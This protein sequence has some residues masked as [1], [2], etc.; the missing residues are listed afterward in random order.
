MEPSLFDVW[1][2]KRMVTDKEDGTK[3]WVSSCAE[4]RDK[5]Y[6]DKYAE[7]NGKDVDPLT[8]PFDPEVAMLAGQ[9]KKHGRL[10]IGDGS[11]DPLI[12]PSMRQVRRGRTS[13]M[14][15]VE[16]RPTVT[17]TAIDQIRVYSSSS[18]I[19]TSLHAFHCNIYDI[20]M[21]KRRLRWPLRGDKGRR[22]RP[23][24]GGWR[25]R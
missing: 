16:T 11:V 5:G 3:K 23:T 15:Q 17:S 24:L 12:V 1:T 13:D 20:L 14:P 10:W 21:T 18:V 25:S 9:G 4:I 2:D 6:R 8:A 7:V 22:P 19:H